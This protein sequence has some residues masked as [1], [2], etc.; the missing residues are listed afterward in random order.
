[1]STQPQEI[2]D[3]VLEQIV[4]DVGSGDL[5]AIEELLRSVPQDTLLAFLPEE[6][7]VEIRG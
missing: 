1:M 6:K 5:T 2:I 4:R 7:L 3:W